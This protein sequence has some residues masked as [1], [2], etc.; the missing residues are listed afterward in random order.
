VKENVS[1][2]WLSPLI[3]EAFSLAEPAEGIEWGDTGGFGPSA[4][5]GPNPNRIYFFMQSS[6]TI[7][8]R[9][10]PHEANAALRV[11]SYSKR[12]I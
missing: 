7:D 11:F 10:Q 12:F 2:K 5:L 3:G 4:A 8:N 6:T 9:G 1:S